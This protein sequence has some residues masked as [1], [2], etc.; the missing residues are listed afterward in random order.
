MNKKYTL[1]FINY[2]KAKSTKKLKDMYTK[3]YK[4]I[5]N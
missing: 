1:F 4:K 5:F 3:I 2:K